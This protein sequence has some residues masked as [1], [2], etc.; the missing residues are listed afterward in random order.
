MVQVQSSWF[1]LVDRNPQKFVDI[2]NARLT[3]FVKATERVY[4]GAGALSGLKVNVRPA[5]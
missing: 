1:P 4:R 3:D 2:Y 5:N